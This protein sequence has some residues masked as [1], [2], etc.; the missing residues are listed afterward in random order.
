MSDQRVASHKRLYMCSTEK[1]KLVVLTTKPSA[2]AGRIVRVVG[3]DEIPSLTA[4]SIAKLKCAD[5]MK[6]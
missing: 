3:D 4:F 1:Q 2:Y 6:G 5:Q